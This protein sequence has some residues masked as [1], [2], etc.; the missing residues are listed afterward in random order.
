MTL[1]FSATITVYSQI[2]ILI[3]GLLI[4]TVS[5]YFV[6]LTLLEGGQALS[7]IRNKGK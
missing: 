5:I 1:F 4:F 7:E 6:K 3:L 2:S